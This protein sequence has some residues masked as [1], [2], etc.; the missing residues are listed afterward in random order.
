MWTRLWLFGLEAKQIATSDTVGDGCEC[1]IKCG[2]I[3]EFSIFTAHH[4][5]DALR[6]VPVEAPDR[7][8]KGDQQVEALTRRQSFQVLC[9]PPAQWRE[10]EATNKRVTGGKLLHEIQ[11]RRRHAAMIAAFADQE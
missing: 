6:N 8:S 3:L 9:K 4:R 5:R 2:F 10:S 7:G 1:C 11:S